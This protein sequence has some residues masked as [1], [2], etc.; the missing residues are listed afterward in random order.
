M[1][2]ERSRQQAL[3]HAGRD[4]D[5]PALR[6]RRD[7]HRR[8]SIHWKPRRSA[9]ST[10]ACLQATSWSVDGRMV[11]GHEAAS[12]PSGTR[13]IP[14][15]SDGES[16]SPPSLDDVADAVVRAT[17]RH[18]PSGATTGCGSAS[19][20][21]ATSDSSRLA[22]PTAGRVD[23]GVDGTHQPH[24]ARCIGCSRARSST[25][26]SPTVSTEAAPRR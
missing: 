4:P 24:R 7:R 5:A 12:T 11:N 10:K 19:V 20:T 25:R 22:T 13:G 15:A 21:E 16:L 18:A 14:P 8:R 3:S 17:A 9:A 23:V 26:S 6:E 2:D 1:L